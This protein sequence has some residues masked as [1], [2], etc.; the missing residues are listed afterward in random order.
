MALCA[1]VVVALVLAKL[2]CEDAWTAA[3][4]FCGFEVIRSLAKCAGS[5]CGS[6]CVT[7]TLLFL[8]VLLQEALNVQFA[9]REIL[10]A[11]GPFLSKVFAF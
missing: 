1:A 11:Q 2:R 9:V 5:R 8:C 10:N 7:V 4:R 6:F 3:R